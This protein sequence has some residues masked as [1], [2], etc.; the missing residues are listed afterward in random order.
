MKEKDISYLYIVIE[1]IGMLLY[2]ML[3]IRKEGNY[4]LVWRY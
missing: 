2:K 4:Y 3:V 1:R